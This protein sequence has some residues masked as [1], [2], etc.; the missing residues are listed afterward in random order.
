VIFLICI[1]RVFSFYFRSDE[2]LIGIIPDD[3]FFYIQLAKHRLADG[4]WTFDGIS[5]TTGFHLL[6][7][8]FLVAI[9]YIFP[10]IDWRE[11]YLA[12]GILS[13]TAMG[14]AALIC[15][16]TASKLYST[17]VLPLIVVPFLSM[18]VLLQSTSMMESW[19]VIFFSAMTFYGLTLDRPKLSKLLIIG[20]FTV[21]MLGSLARTDFGMLPGAIFIIIIIASRFRKNS[22]LVRAFVLLSGA[23]CGVVI[24]LVHN[25]VL[26]GT[27]FQ[28]SA[29]VK[30]HW[31]LVGGHSSGPVVMMLSSMLIPVT[32]TIT[33]WKIFYISFWITA[34]IFFSLASFHAMRWTEY[35]YRNQARTVFF[36]SSLTI[37]GYIFFYRHNSEAL[38]N[39]Y[40]ANLVLPV[41]FCSTAVFFYVLR[42]KV[43][44]V[45]I[46]LASLSILIAIYRIQ[47]IPYP[48]QYGMLQAGRFLKNQ[49]YDH[50][51]GSWNAGIIS[52]FS[53]KPLVQ[54]D[55]LVNDEVLPFIKSNRLF[56]YFKLKKITY[57]IDYEHMLT[58]KVLQKRGGYDD[59]RFDR[60]I[61]PLIVVDNPYI[62][63]GRPYENPQLF[64]IKQGCD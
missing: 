28:A 7:G 63:K 15:S 29:Q 2:Q 30:F 46:G 47:A 6:Y 49:S 37:I 12:V 57:L 10:T 39:W 18:P 11:L 60:C 42:N 16:I 17:K 44:S 36:A 25:Y 61:V 34:F 14:F 40:S 8:Y 53:E 64:V 58:D 56:D 1:I 21:G 3:A 33:H 9:F 5:P 13:S 38:Q 50:T 51:Y 27:L 31:S 19:L 48:H 59:S 22:M 4:F 54:L 20:L 24:A 26:S 62:V 23:T 35:P 32:I 45:A 41:A 52:Y 55:G 43:F